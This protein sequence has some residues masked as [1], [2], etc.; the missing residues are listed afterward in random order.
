MARSGRSRCAMENTVLYLDIVPNTARQ[1]H[2]PSLVFE[3]E[4]I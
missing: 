1:F 4:A 3:M 2:T